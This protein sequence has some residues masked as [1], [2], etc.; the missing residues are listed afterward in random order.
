MISSHFLKSS[1]DADAANGGDEVENGGGKIRHGDVEDR[2]FNQ[3]LPPGFSHSFMSTT[4]PVTKGRHSL[5][6]MNL[7]LIQK[8][9]HIFSIFLFL[10]LIPKV[11]K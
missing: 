11:E 8:R 9:K 10:I 7:K 1:E 2:G 6:L 3:K 4:E 5:S